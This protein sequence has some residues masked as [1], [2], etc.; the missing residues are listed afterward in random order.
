MDIHP[1]SIVSPSA[2]ISSGVKIGAY[3]H[4]GP[5]VSIGKDTEIAAHVVIEGN[6]IIGE[7]NKISPFTTL[8]GPPQ[9]LSYNGERTQLI[10]GNDNI[11]REYVTINCASTKEE[12][13]T[14]IGNKCYLMAYSHVAHDCRLG[15][16][17][18]MANVT[19]L[20][21]HVSVGDH[22]TISGLVAVHQFVRIGGYS[23]LGGVSGITRDI[24]PY[25]KAANAKPKLYGINING[26]SRK[27]FSQ[28]KIDGLKKAYQIIWRKNT[29]MGKGIKQVRKELPLFPELEILLD[30]LATSKRGVTR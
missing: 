26:L 1:S 28:E 10:I 8:G 14:E 16:E 15:D 11:L 21:G 4:I 17:I 20:G 22:A 13:K 7:R 12:W 25:M 9:D 30:F 5:H 18:V 6:T 27:G 23:F 2:K 19:T 3:S 29:N 24:P